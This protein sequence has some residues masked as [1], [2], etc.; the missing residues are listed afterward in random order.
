MKKEERKR[1]PA[2]EKVDLYIVVGSGN[3]VL[4]TL[5]M[6]ITLAVLTHID[7]YLNTTAA[8]AQGCHSLY[9]K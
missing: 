1:K 6:L 9:S 2:K 8:H 5:R 3:K 4:E 7:I